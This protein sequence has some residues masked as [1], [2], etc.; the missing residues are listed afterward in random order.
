MRTNGAVRVGDARMLVSFRR[1]L[2]RTD[3]VH[4]NLLL[5]MALKMAQ[6]RKATKR[7]QKFNRFSRPDVTVGDG[8]AL[9]DAKRQCGKCWSVIQGDEA[10]VVMS[11]GEMGEFVDD[12]VFEAMPWFF[13]KLRIKAD[14]A[15][16][17]I[18]TSPFGLHLLNVK[19]F[20]CNAHYRRPACDNGGDDCFDLFTIKLGNNCFLL[21][22]ASS[23]PEAV[24][25]S[26]QDSV[27]P[28]VGRPPQSTWR[29]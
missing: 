1:L 15:G 17:R 27:Q 26:C 6:R 4:I 14:V 10:I 5:S 24:V 28:Q 11:R 3:Q 29:R 22:F 25:A 7:T 8:S 23:R 9:H 16:N 12:D 21:I 20:N 2:S 13:C 19:P 18:A